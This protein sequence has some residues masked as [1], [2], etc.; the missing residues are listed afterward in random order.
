MIVLRVKH[1]VIVI[2]V[3]VALKLSSYVL[4]ALL[5][6]NKLLQETPSPDGTLKAVLFERNCG[7]TTAYSYQISVLPGNAQ[8]PNS[9][10]NA[11]SSYVQNPSLQWDGD[12]QIL[13]ETPKTGRY[14][15]EKKVGDVSVRYQPYCQNEVL[16]KS[17]SP[18]RQWTAIAFKG[19]CNEPIIQAVQVAIV[20]TNTPRTKQPDTVFV[21]ET[22]ELS[23]VWQGNQ[24]LKIDF[25]D[26]G[27]ILAMKHKQ[28]NI[29]I[30]FNP[31]ANSAK[32]L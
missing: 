28:G 13:I 21:A 24:T 5:C 14:R 6:E 26:M 27:S 18:D 17:I 4:D 19:N 25:L 9:P 29:R 10:G 23:L 12:R 22:N 7:A 3:I 11:F 8:L 1:L 2:L 20:P 31:R 16:F 32:A 30:Q 15:A